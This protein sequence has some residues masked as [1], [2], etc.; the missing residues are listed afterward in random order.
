MPNENKLDVIVPVD[1]VEEDIF[2]DAAQVDPDEELKKQ[3]QK[4]FDDSIGYGDGDDISLEREKALKAF[5]RQKY[6]D[7]QDGRSQFITSDVRDTVNWLL[8]SLLQVFLSQ[9]NIVEFIPSNKDAIAEAEQMT[10]YINYIIT[11]END[12]FRIFYIWLWDA[13]VTKNGYLKYYY[14]ED[15][16]TATENYTGISYEQLI[17]LTQNPDI[18]IVDTMQ[19]GSVVEPVPANPVFPFGISG[20]TPMSQEG[21]PSFLTQPQQTEPSF[22]EKPLYDVTVRR[23]YSDK[24][25]KIENIDPSHVMVH[26][27][28]TTVDDARFM[29]ITYYKTKSELLEDGFDAAVIEDLPTTTNTSANSEDDI[30]GEVNLADDSANAENY[31]EILECYAQ[32]PDDLGHDKLHRIVLC[33]KNDMHILEDVEVDEIPIAVVTPFIKPYSFFGTSVADLVTDIQRVNTT[34][35]RQL[36]DY[37]YTSVMPQW[38]VLDRAIVNKDDIQRRIPGGLVRTRQLGSVQPITQPPFP[39]EIVGLLDRL[40]DLKDA[41]TGV[42]AFNSGLDPDA[43]KA[44]TST[45]GLEMGAAG[46][47]IQDMIARTMAETGFTK[48]FMGIYGLVVKNVNEKKIIRLRGSFVEIDPTSWRLPVRVSANVGLGTG[49]AK[50]K[51]HDLQQML[52]LQLQFMPY[53]VANEKCL[54]NTMSK[55]VGLAGFKDIDSF[56]TNPDLV[57]PPPKTPTPEEVEQQRIQA[58]L[59]KEQMRSDI[60]SYKADIKAQ[61]D[62]YRADLDAEV[63]LTELNVETALKQEALALKFAEGKA[64]ERTDYFPGIRDD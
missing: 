20:D 11:E 53:R 62:K 6:G 10:D 22:V 36:L 37:I 34:L 31:Y 24:R 1:T 47:Q 14:K 2:P 13:L 39:T 21:S 23:Q 12:A 45:A 26:N 48:L 7:E 52:A 58:D 3:L 43:L 64:G 49:T 57:P 38:E 46:R 44:N 35:H 30:R 16:K 29:A 50:A 18:S 41:R 60:D 27:K 56:L 17:A 8:P 32:V 59:Q 19:S 42:T 9:T 61:T 28:A 33:D 5:Y 4:Y 63:K 25:I 55:I 54:Y 15:K 40:R 51:I